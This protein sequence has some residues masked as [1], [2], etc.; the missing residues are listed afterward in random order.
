METLKYKIIKSK[1]QY[2][3]YCK[4]LENLLDDEMSKQAEDEIELLTFLVEKWDEEHN[5]FED[6]DPV[7][8]IKSLMKEHNLISKD[9]ADILEVSKSLISEILNYRKGLSKEIIR[10]L[11]THFKVSQ[12]AFN[13][14]Y[15]LN[16]PVNSS[17]R[18]A[19]VMNTH[20]N[21]I[22]MH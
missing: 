17:L 6:V 11:S 21:L 9:L 16:S 2:N 19:S 10:G 8:L 15:K 12:E 7:T 22:T 3:E 4:M 14:T 20:K 13:R 5:T 1:R 18:N